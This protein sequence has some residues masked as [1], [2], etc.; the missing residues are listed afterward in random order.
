MAEGQIFDVH[1]HLSIADPSIDEDEQERLMAAD[2]EKRVRIMDAY[3][4]AQ[5]ALFPFPFYMRTRG[6]EDTRAMNTLLARYRDQY[7][8][9]FPVVIGTV[10]PLQNPKLGL[11][12]LERMV[13]ELHM[14]AVG[15]HHRAS[16][17]WIYT[18][19]TVAFMRKVEELGVAA[20]I[21]VRAESSLEDPSGLERLAD[22]FSDVTFVAVDA[23]SSMNHAH[24]MVETLKHHPNIL[25]ETGVMN[26][27]HRYTDQFTQL[28]G[29]ERILFG[30]DLNVDPLMWYHPHTL[31]EI[32]LSQVLTDADRQDILWNNARHLL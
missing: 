4:I 2:Y 27:V 20:F 30:S 17:T 16:G 22:E 32:Q 21:H 13:G 25:A 1:Q 26:P 9:R 14:P 23:F 3:G 15:W 12:E 18:P 31:T 19:A 10:E 29:S 6:F 11:E 7:R 8:D 24:R 28:F 5:A